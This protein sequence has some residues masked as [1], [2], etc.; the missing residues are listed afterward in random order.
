MGNVPALAEVAAVLAPPLDLV[1]KL[2]AR[3]LIRRFV[4]P[5]RG[6]LLNDRA[7]WESR[8]GAGRI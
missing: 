8:A 3:H 6:Q 2:G 5:Q 1:L 7:W 4:V